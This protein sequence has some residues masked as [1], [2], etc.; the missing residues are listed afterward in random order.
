VDWFRLAMNHRFPY[1]PL[2]VALYRV[3]SQSTSVVQKWGYCVNRFKGFRRLLRTWH[4]LLRPIRAES[5]LNLGAELSNLE[6]FH[7]SRR[8]IWRKA[9]GL[10]VAHPG[11]LRIFSR[12]IRRL[13]ISPQTAF[14]PTNHA[15]FKPSERPVS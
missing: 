6:K 7:S 15:M 11:A 3:H 4:N 12:T 8:L 2:P 9:I 14:G 1:S 10:S 13:V 5:V